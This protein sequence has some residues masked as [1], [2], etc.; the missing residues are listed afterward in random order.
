ME[1][2]GKYTNAALR[3]GTDLDQAARER[4]DAHIRVLHRELFYLWDFVGEEGLWSDAKEYV[5]ERCIDPIPYE[6]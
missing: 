3:T 4:R 1:Q 2:M 6:W 5:D